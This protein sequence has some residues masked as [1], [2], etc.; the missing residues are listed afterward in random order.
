[1]TNNDNSMRE[2]IEAWINHYRYQRKFDEEKAISIWDSIVGPMI[3]QE[4][5]Q[6]YIKNKTLV[7]KLRSQALKFELEYAKR[8]LISNI[9]RKLNH[10]VIN[11][12]NF[13]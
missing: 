2:A 8:K 10:E 7:V 6:I 1:M 12:I 5:E 9:N 11:E 3:A 4:T 13:I